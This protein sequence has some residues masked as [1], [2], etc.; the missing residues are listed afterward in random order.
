[1]IFFLTTRED[2]RWLGMGLLCALVRHMRGCSK[3]IYLA[4]P[5]TSCVYKSVWGPCAWLLTNS[6]CGGGGG[7]VVERVWMLT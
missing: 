2:G 6:L 7:G 4:L 5:L 1:M 3:N